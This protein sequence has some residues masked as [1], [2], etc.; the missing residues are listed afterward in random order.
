M[1]LAGIKSKTLNA[2]DFYSYCN[3]NKFNKS[4][5]TTLLSNPI[6]NYCS[7]PNKI[8]FILQKPEADQYYNR[9]FFE[10]KKGLF[11]QEYPTLPEKIKEMIKITS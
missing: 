6:T 8:I 3:V 2:V 11:I 1:H 10:I 5:P 7:S 4:I 9:I